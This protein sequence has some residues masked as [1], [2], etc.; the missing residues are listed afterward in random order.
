MR[1][2]KV[3]ITRPGGSP[4]V[5]AAKP[6]TGGSVRMSGLDRL[7]RLQKEEAANADKWVAGLSE[8]ALRGLAADMAR[9]FP[10]D[11]RDPIQ[12]WKMAKKG[13]VLRALSNLPKQP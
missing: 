11:R 1:I 13:A 7:E 2:A 9:E 12:R 10:S 5:E 8:T 6:T 4:P 3:R